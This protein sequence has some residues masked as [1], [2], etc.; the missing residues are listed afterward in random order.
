MQKLTPQNI[1]KLKPRATRYEVVDSE[2][3]GFRLR[4]MPSGVM[5]YSLTYRNPAGK[6]VRFTIGKHRAITPTQA[7]KI[8]GIKLAEVKL[9]KDPQAEKMA[10]RKVKEIPTLTAFLDGDYREWATSNHNDGEETLRRLRTCFSTDFGRQPLDK[11][12]AWNVDVDLHLKLTRDLHL[13]LTHP[14][15]QIMA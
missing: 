3:P 14:E 13:K 8:A 12:S 1:A 15:R 9:G 10:A 6:K 4:V 7:R 11:I 5:T 2:I